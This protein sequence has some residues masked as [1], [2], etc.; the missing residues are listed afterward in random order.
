MS[1]Y[2]IWINIHAVQKVLT[3]KGIFRQNI[4]S[5]DYFDYLDTETS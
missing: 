2:T 4:I 3:I 5:S 1:S